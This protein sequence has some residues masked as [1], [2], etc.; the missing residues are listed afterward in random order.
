MNKIDVYMEQIGKDDEDEEVEYD[1]TISYEI[2]NKYATKRKEA[3]KYQAN[4]MKYSDEE[5]KTEECEEENRKYQKAIDQATKYLRDIKRWNQQTNEE[6]YKKQQKCVDGYQYDDTNYK[7]FFRKFYMAL[8]KFFFNT[9][10]IAATLEQFQDEIKKEM[11]RSYKKITLKDLIGLGADNDD[12]DDEYE[13]SGYESKKSQ[14]IWKAIYTDLDFVMDEMNALC[15]DAVKSKSIYNLCKNATD[16]IKEYYCGNYPKFANYLSH[17]V[18]MIIVD[19]DDPITGNPN[20]LTDDALGAVVL[21]FTDKRNFPLKLFKTIPKSSS[22]GGGGGGDYDDSDDEY[23]NTSGCVQDAFERILAAVIVA[24]CKLDAYAGKDVILNQ[25]DLKKIN[26]QKQWVLG[27]ASEYQLDGKSCKVIENFFGYFF[28][29]EVSA[30][31]DCGG[32]DEGG[33]FGSLFGWMC[34]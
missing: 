20:H 34:K 4:A 13:N 33:F 23:G 16:F 3:K 29:P 7:E 32:G 9:Q 22:S 30:C 19:P 31:C 15:S 24:I 5:D 17:Y 25:E 26:Q 1:T 18:C 27:K 11:K 14:S 8:C 12:D 2:I 21:L 28:K 10:I 6:L